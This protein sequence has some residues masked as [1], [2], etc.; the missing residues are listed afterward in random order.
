MIKRQYTKQEMRYRRLCENNNFFVVPKGKLKLREDNDNSNAY[1]EPSS[2]NGSSTSL[3][4]DLAKT[5]AENPQDDEYVFN[6][7]SY[8]GDSA[9]QVPTI[10]IKATNPTNAATEYNKLVTQNPEVKN[11]VRKGA[12][13]KVHLNTE[14]LEYRR[15]NSIPFTKAELNKLLKN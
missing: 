12:N 2:S 4:T 6:T 15:Q 1:V 8:D 5:V 14:S 3:A 10:D 7:K 11:L 13:V 9:T